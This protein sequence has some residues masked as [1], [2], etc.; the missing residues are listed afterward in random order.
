MLAALIL[1]RL[2]SAAP[3]RGS[4][5]ANQL[6]REAM[7]TL[8]AGKLGEPV[9]DFAAKRPPAM[10][11]SRGR[12]VALAGNAIAQGRDDRSYSQVFRIFQVMKM[13][14]V[15]SS[16]ISKA[17]KWSCLPGKMLRSR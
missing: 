10:L 8:R 12:F 14:W 6:L 13:P 4:T 15:S 1:A 9:F 3:Q 16:R 5:P 7:D 11:R 17:T 2:P